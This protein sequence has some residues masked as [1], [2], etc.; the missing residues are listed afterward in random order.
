MAAPTNTYSTAVAKG[1][2]EDLE[3][4]IYRVA[5]DEIPFTKAI[6]SVD[7]KAVRHDWQTETLAAPNALN[8]TLEGDDVGTFEAGNNTVR[9]S[10]TCQIFRKTYVIS[11]TQEA[12]TAAGRKSDLARQKLLKGKE[13]LT[14]MEARFLGNYAEKL[15]EAGATP[16]TMSGALAWLTSNTSRGTGGVDGGFSGGVTTAATNGAQRPFIESLLKAVLAKA[17][18]N[19]AKVNG[20][21]MFVGSF[22]KQA[23]SAFTGIAAQ[24]HEVGSGRADIIAGADIYVSDFGS[25]QFVYHPYCST[26]DAFLADTSMWAVATLRPLDSTELSK[27]G[28]NM[29]GA[30]IAEKTLVCRNEKS[31]AVIRDLNAS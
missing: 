4:T 25:V 7:A 13:I 31:S 11:G 24:R 3:D 23:A 27:T 1:N 10:N 15:D 2:R 14:D 29:K 20:M 6:G 5:V 21:K 19:G 8:A 18:D 22:N 30:M 17:A 16:R 9:V 26:R 12:V 28:D